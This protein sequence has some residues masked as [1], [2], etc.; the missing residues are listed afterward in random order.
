MA[1]FF[2][3]IHC[4]PD[5]T[6]FYVGKGNQERIKYV[7]RSNPHHVNVVAKYGLPNIQV[8]TYPCRNEEESFNL[9]IE[10]IRI[11]RDDMGHV[12]ANMTDG[13]EGCSGLV[14]TE[15]HV[16]KRIT[17]ESRIKALDTLRLRMKEGFV[18]PGPPEGF[19]YTDEMRHKISE[20]S[21]RMHINRSFEDRALVHKKISLANTGRIQTE[22]SKEKN[23]QWHL[24]RRQSKKTKKLRAEKL[25]GTRRSEETKALMAQKA[26]E[27]EEKKRLEREL[28]VAPPH[29]N[30]GRVYT[31]EQRQKMSETAKRVRAQRKAKE[32]QNNGEPN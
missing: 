19:V 2:V 16:K 21:K 14:H 29:P 13:G 30:K 12:L 7:V 6:P 15:E 4:K 23:R 22:E 25:R 32:L 8:I 11:L 3:Y 17:P 26:K 10:M 1:K 27:R 20:A 31:P 18:N 9:E 28:G 24:G 5:G